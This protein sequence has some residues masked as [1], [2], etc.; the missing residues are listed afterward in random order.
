MLSKIKS[1]ATPTKSHRTHKRRPAIS[2]PIPIP[3]CL[4]PQPVTQ[5]DAWATLRAAYEAKAARSPAS[6]ISSAPSSCY[7][8]DSHDSRHSRESSGSSL[9]P[10][11]SCRRPHRHRPSV[12]RVQM[13]EKEGKDADI[14]AI[15]TPTAQHARSTS[16][17]SWQ[18]LHELIDDS[19]EDDAASIVSHTSIVTDYE[20][21]QYSIKRAEVV[22]L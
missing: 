15:P 13:A 2:A 22:S 18:V 1:M 9:E 21:G 5:E 11:T 3:T 19:C 7:S 17:T 10:T 4:Q 6:S 12:R 20:E 16:A 14:E 8:G